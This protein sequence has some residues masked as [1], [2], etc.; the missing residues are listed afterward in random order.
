MHL[1]KG[2]QLVLVDIGSGEW[3]SVA[4]EMR[5]DPP[6]VFRLSWSQRAYCHQAS[7]IR[8]LDHRRVP[9]RGSV[10]HNFGE[11]LGEGIMKILI[12][13]IELLVRG[14][15]ITLAARTEL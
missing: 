4:S 12:A 13:C 14:R 11:R 7:I 8:E 2:F 6:N 5:N 1:R 15:C 9:A 3:D 10:E